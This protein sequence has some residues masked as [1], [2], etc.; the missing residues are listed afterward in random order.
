MEKVINC[1]NV[2]DSPQEQTIRFLLRH[3]ECRAALMHCSDEDA[4]PASVA[5]A[6]T[7]EGMHQDPPGAHTSAASAAVTPV[8]GDAIAAGDSCAARFSRAY[9]AARHLSAPDGA[10]RSISSVQ[11]SRLKEF[12]RSRS[13]TAATL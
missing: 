3:A 6:L 2:Q 9:A 10:L 12:P 11:K 13:C 8:S 4:Q 5:P 1:V 7:A